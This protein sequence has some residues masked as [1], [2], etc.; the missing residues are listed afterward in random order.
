MSDN[1]YNE[2]EALKALH[3]LDVQRM[4]DELEARL[5]AV[6]ERYPKKRKPWLGVAVSGLVAAS[7]LLVFS[8][9]PGREGVAPPQQYSQQEID[10]A[11]KELALAFHYLSDASQQTGR[12][13]N[14]RLSESSSAA[15]FKAAGYPLKGSEEKNGQHEY[16]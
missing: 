3:K 2:N 14:N 7:V 15:L 13:L 4:P 6:P 9:F 11:R 16:Q 10:N 5:L 8:H 12:T 1:I